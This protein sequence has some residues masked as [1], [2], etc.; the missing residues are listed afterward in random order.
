MSIVQVSSWIMKEIH[1]SNVTNDNSVKENSTEFPCPPLYDHTKFKIKS[2][3][4]FF[5]LNI[6]KSFKIYFSNR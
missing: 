5:D 6:L 3:V 2:Q 4:L 1:P